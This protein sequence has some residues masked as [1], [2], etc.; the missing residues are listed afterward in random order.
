MV[1]VTALSTC[2]I[3]STGLTAGNTSSTYLVYNCSALPWGGLPLY[4]E[5]IAFTL[6]V[7]STNGD[8][9]NVGMTSGKDCGTFTN[10]YTGES[11][12]DNSGVT[13]C[14]IHDYTKV[15]NQSPWCLVIQSK[16]ASGVATG[17][18][19]DLD[20]YPA[21]YAAQWHLH[22]TGMYVC[23]YIILID[24]FSRIVLNSL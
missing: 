10:F 22:N 17:I 4:T 7:L 9:I 11:C 18:S 8:A 14:T 1:P 2:D 19:I 16:T 21:T 23:M 3:H 12:I 6:S 24:V 13:N 5:Q 20:Y 15:D